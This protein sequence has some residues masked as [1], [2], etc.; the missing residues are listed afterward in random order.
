VSPQQAVLMNPEL[1]GQEEGPV[2][3]DVVATAY[4]GHQLDE[5]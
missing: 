3:A 5:G 4:E 2:L 1:Q